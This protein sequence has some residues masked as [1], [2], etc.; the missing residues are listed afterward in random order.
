MTDLR[1]D[2]QD[3]LDAEAPFFDPLDA[4]IQSIKA[5][6]NR[7]RLAVRAR[8]EGDEEM[9]QHHVSERDYHIKR[10]RQYRARFVWSEE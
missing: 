5:A 7:S 6:R 9:A 1:R 2:L 10:M 8:N 4:T 3:S